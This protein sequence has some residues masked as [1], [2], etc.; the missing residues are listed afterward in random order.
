MCIHKCQTAALLSQSF[1][2]KNKIYLKLSVLLKIQ[3]SAP[4]GRRINKS[5]GINVP[6]KYDRKLRGWYNRNH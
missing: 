2:H 5:A 3:L 4:F 1:F 6:T